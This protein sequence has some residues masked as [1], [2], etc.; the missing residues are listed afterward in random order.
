MKRG[1]LA[2]GPEG[3]PKPRQLGRDPVAATAVGADPHV[4]VVARPVPI[5]RSDRQTAALT[6]VVAVVIAP[7]A[8][9]VARGFPVGIGLVIAV[10]V[11]AGVAG[12]GIATVG[13]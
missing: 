13:S 11:A 8:A 4:A 6:V 2:G 9:P 7:A 1:P 12:R 10:V 3:P 5:G